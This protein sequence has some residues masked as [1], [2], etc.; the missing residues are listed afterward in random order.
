[1]QLSEGGLSFSHIADLSHSL[2]ASLENPWA[3]VVQHLDAE[4]A[5]QYG[6]NFPFSPQDEAAYEARAQQGENNPFA[7][8]DGMALAT[9]LGANSTILSFAARINST[10]NSTE[11]LEDINGTALF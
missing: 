7:R 8:D 11:F 6:E 2:G 5:I 3:T 9:D 10:I 1:M 4:K